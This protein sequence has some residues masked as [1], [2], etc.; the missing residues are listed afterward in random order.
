MDRSY[1]K[2]LKYTDELGIKKIF[3]YKLKYRGKLVGLG[4][5]SEDGPQ[6]T[7]CFDEKDCDRRIAEL[8]KCDAY[9]VGDSK[10]ELMEL[11]EMAKT[12]GL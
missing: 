11:L 4:R 1:K 9:E 5:Y 3:L 2:L 12:V 10:E 7:P 6:L 8:T